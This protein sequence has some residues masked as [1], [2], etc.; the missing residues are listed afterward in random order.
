[1]GGGRGGEGGNFGTGVEVSIL[2]PTPIIYLALGLVVMSVRV[3]ESVFGNQPQAYTW[4]L[5]KTQTI[6]IL[7]FTAS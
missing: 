4:P 3:C 7:D 6:H 1:M 5:K 2:K